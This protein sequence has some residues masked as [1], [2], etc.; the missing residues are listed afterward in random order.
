MP[1]GT[2][3]PF[4]LSRVTRS[5]WIFDLRGVDADGHR[6]AVRLVARHPLDVDAPLLAVDLRHLALAVVEVAAADHHLVV[7]A[8]G[9]RSDVVLRAELLTQRRTHQLAA[10]AQHAMK[11]KATVSSS[12]RKSRK[13]YF[14]A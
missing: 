5:T 4:A 1:M 12:R 9:Q 3:W 2:V 7:P 6:L 8:N 13:A 14:T 10:E 11:Q